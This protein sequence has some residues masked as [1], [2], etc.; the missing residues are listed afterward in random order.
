MRKTSATRHSITL[1]S[2]TIDAATAL[3]RALGVRPLEVLAVAEQVAQN[4]QATHITPQHIEQVRQ[5]CGA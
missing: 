2:G 4:E 3:A 5:F 1:A